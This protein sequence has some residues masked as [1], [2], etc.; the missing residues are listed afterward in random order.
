MTLVVSIP[1]NDGVV[2][3]CDCLTVE[4]PAGDKTRQFYLTDKYL[5]HTEEKWACVWAGGPV[6]TIT[7]KKIQRYMSSDDKRLSVNELVKQLEIIAEEAFRERKEELDGTSE[8]SQCVVVYDHGDTVSLYKLH[9]CPNSV[10]VHITGGP[11]Y[12]GDLRN[13]VTFF[14]ISSYEKIFPDRTVDQ[15]ALFAGFNVIAAHNFNPSEINGLSVLICKPGDFRVLPPPT[16]EEIKRQS[17]Q[18]AENIWGDIRARC[19]AFQPR[20]AEK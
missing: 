16:L 2:V 11:Q 13:P 12:I 5:L 17:E 1:C 9:I 14:G 4:Y 20:I 6:S 18:I 8:T 7:C 3:A 10:A 19:S 15:V